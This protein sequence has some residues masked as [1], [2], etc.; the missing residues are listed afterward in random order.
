MRIRALTAL[1]A[2][3]LASAVPTSSA[4][5]GPVPG[6]QPLP[7]Y[8]IDNPPLAPVQVHGKPSRVLQGV[9]R[10]AAY[11]IEVPPRWNGRLALWA[12]GYAGQGFVLTVSP[13]PFGLRQ[14][15]LDQ[16]Y[17]W[18]AS[19]YYRNGYDVRAGVLST[20]D[21]ADLF[22]A[23]VGRP[24]QRIIVGASMGGHII[25]RSLEQFPGYYDGALPMCGVLGDHELFDYFL[26]YNLV[27]QDLSGVREYPVTDRYATV[28]VPKIEAALGLTDLRPGGPD[29]TNERG[30][31][32]RSI[33]INR[34]GGAR[35]GDVQSFAFW[36]DFPFTLA[37]PEPPDATLA[38]YPGQ[39]ATNLF[40]RYEPNAP[41]NVNRSVQ[42]V[43]VANL[44]AR[45]SNRLSQVPRVNGR[46]NVP[47]LSLHGLGDL[48]VPFSM[49]QIYAKEVARNHRSRLLVQRA[50]RT[51]QHCEFSDAEAG[52]AWDDL[53]RWIDKG[54]RPAG[55]VTTK[56]STVAR[57]D[58]GCRFSDRAAYAAGA[59]TRRLFPACP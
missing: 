19:S 24:K 5:A 51:V 14:R 2:L 4:E 34:T 13:P 17:A 1:A 16:G 32:F 6:D 37:T 9:H 48:F 39:L 59:G 26:D 7:G 8:T 47:V 40:T 23:K 42:R 49:E 35:P 36:K 18:A 3:V 46:P 15:L 58:Y 25:G 33:A 22:A 20:R 21:V 10:H 27:A 44:P 52:A 38:E 31:Q 41:V 45:L 28:T 54:R 11:D 12:H 53:V 56:P 29:T 55:D 50:V 30:R 43:R 57:P